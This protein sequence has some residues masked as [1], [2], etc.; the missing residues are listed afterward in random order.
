LFLPAAEHRPITVDNVKYKVSRRIILS[1]NVAETGITLNGLKYVIDS[2]Y[3]RTIEYFP[4]NGIGGLITKPAPISSIIQRI[5]RV[6][7][8]APGYFYPL[9]PKYI[10][11]RL[12]KQRLPKI[13]TESIAPICFAMYK[14][15]GEI[16][17]PLPD[18]I[19]PPSKAA[20]AETLEKMYNLG[21]IEYSDEITADFRLKMKFTPMGMMVWDI[22]GLT[23]E[24]L[25]MIL[26][27]LFWKVHIEDLITIAA[28]LES[29]KA[30]SIVL[31]RKNLSIGKSFTEWA[32][33]QI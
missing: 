31:E 20:I 12:Q 4:E 1:T 13:L 5:G 10:Y 22:N 15:Q 27:S 30:N 14:T 32:F 25:R 7:R 29:A 26:A 2:G 24:S 8:T 23:P 18:M 33:R 9:Y 3:D 19:D 11:D 21:F 28:Y 16:F 17:D 6:G